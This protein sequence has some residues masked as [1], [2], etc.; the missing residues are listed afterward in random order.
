MN[1]RYAHPAHLP[2]WKTL[3]VRLGIFSLLLGFFLGGSSGAF[4]ESPFND[5]PVAIRM[6]KD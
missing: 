2:V 5:K 6:G 4:A 1:R 3:R